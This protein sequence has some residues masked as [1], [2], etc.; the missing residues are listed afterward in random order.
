MKFNIC[1]ISSYL[2]EKQTWNTDKQ[3]D[4]LKFYLVTKF[5]FR[6]NDS[7]EKK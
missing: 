2:E 5:G 6:V 7:D 3:K 4:S 1:I